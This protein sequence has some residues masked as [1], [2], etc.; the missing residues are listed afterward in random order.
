MSTPRVRPEA[1]PCRSRH[2]AIFS[3]PPVPSHSP[4]P[5]A[6][7]SPP[8]VRATSS[9][10][11]GDV[12][13][14]ELVEGPVSFVDTRNNRREGRAQL[15]PVQTVTAGVPFGRPYNAPFAVR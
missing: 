6:E 9:I 3:P 2:A 15:K 4:G 10:S 7:L 8:W 13:I 14:M 11:S 12:A 1:E 5:A